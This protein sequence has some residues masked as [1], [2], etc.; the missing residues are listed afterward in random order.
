[1]KCSRPR[2]PRVGVHQGLC[3]PHRDTLVAQGVIGRTPSEA[4]L[5]HMLKLAGL[6]WPNTAIAQQSGVAP[7]TL[8]AIRSGRPILRATERSILAM[9]LIPYLSPKLMLPAVGMRRRHQ[10]LA[11]M[12]WTLE[13]SAGRA[14]RSEESFC[15]MLARGSVSR[16]YWLGYAAVYDELKD[17][18]GPSDRMRRLA[19]L[20]GWAPP[21]A[22]DEESIDDPDAH[23]NLTGYDEAIVRA[24]IEGFQPQHRTVDR[25]EAVRR[26]GYL[27]VAELARLFGVSRAAVNH[28]RTEQE[29][30]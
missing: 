22:W 4:A 19:R 28:V 7:A 10:A 18:P 13:E 6:D 15:T 24:L 16:R 20:R 17:Q 3:N 25:A 14:G 21:A 27:S 23:P 26:L 29:A 2:C 9:P 30:A 5:S 1:M 8:R 11:W 12:G